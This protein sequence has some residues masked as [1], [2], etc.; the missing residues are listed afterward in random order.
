MRPRSAG[1]GGGGMRVVMPPV[2]NAA[3]ALA[4]V[5]FVTS[6]V[7][8]VLKDIGVSL[9][10][11]PSGLLN[12]E[13]LWQPITWIPT[14]YGT[15]V[16]WTMLIVWMTGGSLESLWGRWRFVRF[17][18]G[19]VFLTG[20]AL[21]PVAALLPRA[22]GGIHMGGSLLATCCWVGYGCA[23]WNRLTNVWGFEITGRTMA[24]FGV[25]LTTLTAFFSSPFAVVAQAIALAFTFAYARF[26]WPTQLLTAFGSWRL[27]RELDRRSKHL[28]VLSGEGQQGP[29][30]SDKYLH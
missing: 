28:K 21:V 26:G 5:V 22:G 13:Q 11:Q 19:V 29:R 12:G 24:M 23:I 27:R 20:L 15:G 25:L 6:I 9:Y 17:V 18:V 3:T 10:L 7:A 2:R 1:G 4:L 8:W 14:D 16:L 30:G